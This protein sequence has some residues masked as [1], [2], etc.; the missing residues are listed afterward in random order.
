MFQEVNFS[1]QEAFPLQM[2]EFFFVFFFGW[3]N[4][5]PVNYI[6]E[7]P[8]PKPQKTWTR[9]CRRCIKAESSLLNSTISPHSTRQ[10]SETSGKI[11]TAYICVSLSFMSVSTAVCY[12]VL[13]LILYPKVEQPKIKITNKQQVKALDSWQE[14]NWSVHFVTKLLSASLD[15]SSNNG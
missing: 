13:C 7:V 11:K 10:T 15:L 12:F 3:T 8:L 4:K 2:W 1:L 6:K 14:F 9:M 5:I